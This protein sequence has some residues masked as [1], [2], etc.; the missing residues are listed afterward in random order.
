MF[1]AL[2]KLTDSGPHNCV[3]ILD[4]FH[5]IGKTPNV[6]PWSFLSLERINFIGKKLCKILTKK[7]KLHCQLHE[8]QGQERN[9]KI[10]YTQ[11]HLLHHC[12]YL[13]QV[14]LSPDSLRFSVSGDEASSTLLGEAPTFMDLGGILEDY[15]FY[16]SPFY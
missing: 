5:Y 15:Y 6:N 2:W 14:H 3:I 9:F 1:S 4:I 10:H 13:C 11:F 12:T 7:H 8:N 16:S